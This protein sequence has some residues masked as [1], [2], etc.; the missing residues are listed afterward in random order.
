MKD[1]FVWWM[2]KSFVNKVIWQNMQ[3]SIQVKNIN[4]VK[5]VK[6]HLHRKSSC[7][8]IKGFILVKSLMHVIYVKS[9][10]HIKSSC[11]H[12]KGSIQVKNNII[13]KFVKSHSRIVV[14]LLC[15]KGFIRGSSTL[16]SFYLNLISVKRHSLK[17][18]HWHKIKELIKVKNHML[19]IFMLL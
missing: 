18:I 6:S 8:H 12:I 4:I 16:S 14:G 17:V 10:L 1:W 13:V 15:I 7:F 5:F 19:V 11:F 9:H 2:G 3:R